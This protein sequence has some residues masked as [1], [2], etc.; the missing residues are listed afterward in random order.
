M[1]GKLLSEKYRRNSKFR[2][3]ILGH[4]WAWGSNPFFVLRQLNKH[5]SLQNIKTLKENKTHQ[6]YLLCWTSFWRR[7][8]DQRAE[9]DWTPRGTPPPYCFLYTSHVQQPSLAKHV[10]LM[11]HHTRIRSLTKLPQVVRNNQAHQSDVPSGYCHQLLNEIIIIGKCAT[12][13]L[14]K[15]L[16][17]SGDTKTWIR[18][19]LIDH[20]NTLLKRQKVRDRV[21]VIDLICPIQGFSMALKYWLNTTWWI[22]Q[23][24]TYKIKRF[25]LIGQFP[26]YYCFV[27]NLITHARCNTHQLF[28]PNK[29]HWFR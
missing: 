16:W 17:Q 26:I 14:Y 15:R 25:V 9:I 29:S 18:P 7:C 13:T 12:T 24:L 4:S 10:D 1:Q 27:G 6:Q 20:C 2:K 22:L 28:L 23:F 3:V 21:T 11:S 8:L 5:K 19:D